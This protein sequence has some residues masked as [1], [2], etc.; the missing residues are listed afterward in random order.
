MFDKNETRLNRVF[1]DVSVAL[2]VP[3]GDADVVRQKLESLPS[4]MDGF[5][6]LARMLHPPVSMASAACVRSNA[7]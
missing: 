6:A 4:D 1:G 7:P 3:E 5:H 2:A